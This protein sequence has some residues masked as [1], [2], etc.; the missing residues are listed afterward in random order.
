MTGYKELSESLEIIKSEKLKL[1]E[2][3]GS[4]VEMKFTMEVSV[5][6]I[7]T[8]LCILGF[9][10]KKIKINFNENCNFFVNFL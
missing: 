1:E 3:L 2:Y 10:G 9:L 8:L 4:K 7:S 6:V 5:L